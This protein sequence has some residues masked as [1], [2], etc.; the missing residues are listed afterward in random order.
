VWPSRGIKRYRI[1]ADIQGSH[2]TQTLG[3]EQGSLQGRVVLAWISD[4]LEIMQHFIC[5]DISHF[6]VGVG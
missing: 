6:R 3:G 5:G 2:Y 4:F 1:N